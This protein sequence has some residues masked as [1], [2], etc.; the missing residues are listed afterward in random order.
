M[1]TKQAANKTQAVLDYLKVH[2]AAPTKDIVAALD[3]QGIRITLNHVAT[4]KAAMYEAAPPLPKPADP[5]TLDQ[6]KM[7]AHAIRRIRLRTETDKGHVAGEG[8]SLAFWKM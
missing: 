1:A 5:L 7:V 2:P 4:I 8:T 3:K 6:I